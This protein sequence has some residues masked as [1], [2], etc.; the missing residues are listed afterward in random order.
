MTRVIIN[1]DDLGLSGRVNDAIF[2]LMR[3]GRL[4]SSTIMANGPALE[5]AAART[6]EFPRCSFGVHL[7]L[8][9]LR[10]VT[11]DPT[12]RP[13]LG[14]AGEFARK[15]REV[16]YD[17]AL[18]AA[19]E[20]EWITQ[21]N[22]VRSLGVPVSHLDSHHHTHT[23]APLFKV[24]KRVQ[25][26]TGIRRVRTTM[27]LYHPTD[28]LVGG[29]KQRLKKLGWHTALRWMAPRTTT[30]DLFT[31]FWIYHD[32]LPTVPRARTVEL[33][34]HPG[35]DDPIFKREEE[36]MDTPWEARSKPPISLVSYNDL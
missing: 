25:A 30:T 23:H 33:M 18:L 14:D 8:T 12:L 16:S 4:T 35:S 11:G 34:V 1:A 3:R 9:D 27:N 28:P 2:G 10:P 24:L 5:D 26:M 20:R 19:V 21:V 36:L 17:D 22:K 6:K 32:L 7:N 31:W 29:M 15:A 13:L